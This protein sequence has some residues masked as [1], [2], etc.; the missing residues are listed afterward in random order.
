MPA[1]TNLDAAVASCLLAHLS[2]RSVIGSRLIALVAVVVA[3]AA[4]AA[5]VGHQSRWAF[6]SAIGA[7]LLLAHHKVSGLQH[8]N[9]VTALDAAPYIPSA[10][11][12]SLHRLARQT[13]RDAS[14]RMRLARRGSDGLPWDDMMCQQ[15]PMLRLPFDGWRKT[16]ST[17]H[18]HPEAFTPD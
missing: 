7:S 8:T 5:A 2:F 12:H 16:G 4:A 3:A 14:R 17:T 10:L 11:Q 13:F 1:T 15:T 6:P 18:R 9:V